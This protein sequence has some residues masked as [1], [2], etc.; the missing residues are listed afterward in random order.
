MGFLALQAALGGARSL[1]PSVSVA[2]ASLTIAG[3]AASQT[4][5][6]A[7]ATVTNGLAPFTYSWAQVSGGAFTIDSPNTASTTFTAASLSAAG[8]TRT[9]VFHC[10]VTDH[11]GRVVTSSDVN[12]SI[13]RYATLTA[14]ASPAS[15]SGSGNTAT[16][17]SGSATCTP[18]GGSGNFTYSWVRVSGS[19]SVSAVSATAATSAFRATTLTAGQ[20]LSA[21]FRCDVTDTTTG[22]TASSGN[23]SVSVNRYAALT[24][25]VSP[26]SISGSGTT[27]TITT[28]TSAVVTPA[29]GSGNYSFSWTKVSG[30]TITAV[31]P[32][33]ASSKFR[34]ASTT[35]GETRTAVFHCTVTDTTT[36]STAVAANVS[37]TINNTAS[38][39]GSYSPAA[40]S[41]SATDNDASGASLLDQQHGV[42]RLDVQLHRF[43]SGL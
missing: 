9:G 7:T 26:T 21:V 29:G 6:A 13:Q 15:V 38:S 1:P 23:V 32:T 30:G 28:A 31:S 42:G 10:T 40:G 39:G 25:S 8:E 4:T 18:S 24:A 34:A 43:C 27:A 16:V 5:G 14:S 17:S 35:A 41:Y 12:V 20:T 11:V 3:A 22:V 2:P 19:T 36:G 37:I 33:S